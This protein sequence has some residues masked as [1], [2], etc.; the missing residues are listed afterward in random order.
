M[1]EA[2]QRDLYCSW[3]MDAAARHPFR[4]EKDV[5]RMSAAYVV[6]AKAAESQMNAEGISA[7]EAHA[8]SLMLEER[9]ARDHLQYTLKYSVDACL[10][11]ADELAMPK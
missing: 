4:T 9:A 6:L 10:A 2:A 8:A 1:S 5:A 11:R 3:A 7:K